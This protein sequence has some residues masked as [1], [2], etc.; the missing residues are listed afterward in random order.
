[1]PPSDVSRQG[2]RLTPQGHLVPDKDEDSPV[3]DDKIAVRL[4]ETFT[5]GSGTGLI[6]LG[7]F[8]PVIIIVLAVGYVGRRRVRFG[9]RRKTA[10]SVL[11][12]DSGTRSGD[13]SEADA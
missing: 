5:Q 7:I 12:S 4:V 2:L 3:L 1:M 10:S 6:W 11:A 13:G 9:F 8:S